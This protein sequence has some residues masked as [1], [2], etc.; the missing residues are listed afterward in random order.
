MNGFAISPRRVTALNLPG[1][2][3]M[4]P[5]DEWNSDKRL[6]HSEQ[7]VER[8]MADL[9]QAKPID[10]T[11]PSISVD[12][13][14]KSVNR[15]LLTMRTRFG[16]FLI[17]RVKPFSI[18][19]HDLDKVLIVHPASNCEVLD[20]TKENRDS[21]RYIMCSQVLWYAFAYSWG[22]GAMEVSGMYLDRCFNVPNRLAF[23]LNIMATEFLGFSGFR[24]TA[25]TL[26]FFWAK[27]CELA[28]RL[29]GSRTRLTMNRPAADP[30]HVAPPITPTGAA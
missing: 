17:G 13:L 20:G 28:Y 2:N 21:A 24:Q 4:Y 14:Q 9:S 25:R 8:Y 3:F 10:S 1:I 29:W 19:L 6:F 22:W 23:Y 12:I 15:T 7:A 5:G 26:E 18:Y 11:P 30:Q 16:R 27:R